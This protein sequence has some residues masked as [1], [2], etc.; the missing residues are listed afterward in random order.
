HSWFSPAEP[1][2]DQILEARVRAQLGRLVS[3]P[4]SISVSASDGRITLSGPIL[5]DEVEH[6]LDRVAAIRGV[7]AVENAL[8]IHEQADNVPGLQGQPA[9]RGRERSEFMQSNWS[10]AARFIAGITG[11]ALALYGMGWRGLRQ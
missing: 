7:K 5:A 4:H 8:E 11:G 9:R 1:V 10:P 2:S 6:L 3:H